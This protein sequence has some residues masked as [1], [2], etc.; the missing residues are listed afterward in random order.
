MKKTIILTVLLLFIIQNVSAVY[1]KEVTNFTGCYGEYKVKVEGEKPI[2]EWFDLVDCGD[3]NIGYWSCPCSNKNLTLVVNDSMYNV[4]DFTIEY[5]YDDPKITIDMT[6]DEII[7]Q[8]DTYRRTEQF[9]NI[10]VRKPPKIPINISG[11]AIAMVVA[12]IVVIV[13]VVIVG[14][15]KMISKED[16]KPEKDF[17]G[18]SS[19]FKSEEDKI[20]DIEAE[21]FL[22]EL[23]KGKNDM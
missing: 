9:N 22:E 12:V 18:K 14:L 13:I 15:F 1:T 17:F 21:K 5:Y 4:Y 6:M 10:V 2:T 20:S 3:T 8:R 16:K 11:K 19:S 7:N 23:E